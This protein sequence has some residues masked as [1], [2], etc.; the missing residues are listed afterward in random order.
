M[1]TITVTAETLALADSMK[2]ADGFVSIRPNHTAKQLRRM[3]ELDLIVSDPT[4]D[5]YP[6]DI[7]A[8]NYAHDIAMRRL[9]I[10][11]A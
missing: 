7:E 5:E 11:V 6:R 3:Y 8:T 2:S 1:A 10:N 4:D 9:S